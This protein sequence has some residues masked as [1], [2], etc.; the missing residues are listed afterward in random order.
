M[1]RRR[2]LQLAIL[3]GVAVSTPWITSCDTET[4]QD[5]PNL[6]GG[7]IF[8]HEEMKNIYAFQNFLL[9][10]EGDGPSAGEMNAHQYF[11][12]SLSD[13]HFSA[14]DKDYFVGKSIEVFELCK[15]QMSKPFHQLVEMEMENFILKNIS[16][17]WFESYI[18]R[19][20]TVIFEATLLDPIYGGNIDEKGWE[21]L[22]HTPGSPRPN[23]T[24][25][26]PEILTLL[27][28][29]ATA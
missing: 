6:D 8:T 14:S 7:G 13:K 16:E 10:A 3:G 22:A 20:I 9:P 17:S 2:W 5:E 24:T 21:W 27:K 29:T 23:E 19:M 25:K 18:A 26:Y 4:P 12:W 11:I 15:E 28:P 1:N